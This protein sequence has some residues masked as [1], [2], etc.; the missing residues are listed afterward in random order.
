M[1]TKGVHFLALDSAKRRLA[2]LDEQYKEV[3]RQLD[4]AIKMGDLR[5]N[6][7]YDIAK[8]NKNRIAKE[9]DELIPVLTMPVVRSNDNLDIIEEGSIIY[10]RI[11]SQTSDPVPVGTPEFEA[12]KTQPAEF[13]GL[14]MFGGTLNYQEFMEH[15]ALSTSSAV[16]KFILGKP[17][18]DYSVPVMSGYVN[19]TVRKEK[20]NVSASDLY[21]NVSV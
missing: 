5:E 21:C 18:G 9:R 13:E 15:K 16:G 19:I 4:E 2:E 3:S 10:L 7:E 20:S 1:S 14:L 11:H 8:A 6:A 17:S 12:L